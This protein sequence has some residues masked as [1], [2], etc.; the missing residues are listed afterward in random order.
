MAAYSF[1]TCDQTLLF[2]KVNTTKVIGERADEVIGFLHS[3]KKKKRQEDALAVISGYVTAAWV[4][5]GCNTWAEHGP[6]EF[7]ACL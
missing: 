5:R 2:Q 7:T 1:S 6:E 3:K 4:T